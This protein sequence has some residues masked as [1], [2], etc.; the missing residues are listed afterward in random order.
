MDPKKCL[1]RKKLEHIVQLGHPSFE[2][3]AGR[4]RSRDDFQYTTRQLNREYAPVPKTPDALPCPKAT[5][6]ELDAL[7]QRMHVDGNH[8]AGG[9]LR[10]HEGSVRCCSFSP[11]GLRDCCGRL[12]A[13][14]C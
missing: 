13:I 9:P 8:D 5:G 1:L 12:T 7:L 3:H 11:D 2:K 4:L 14:C 6:A 10:G